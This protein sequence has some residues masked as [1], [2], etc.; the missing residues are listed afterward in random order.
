MKLNVFNYFN[1][2]G[3][4]TL[5]N[6]PLFSQQNSYGSGNPECVLK[7]RADSTS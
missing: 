6:Q 1:A 4:I 3:F 5:R 7:L 2:E